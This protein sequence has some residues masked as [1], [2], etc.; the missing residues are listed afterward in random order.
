MQYSP[1]FEKKMPNYMDF[2]NTA[3][4]YRDTTPS[5][6][7]LKYRICHHVWEKC[8]MVAKMIFRINMSFSHENFKINIITLLRNI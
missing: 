5:Q 6:T 7:F 1:N 3:S 4:K 2:F 8:A